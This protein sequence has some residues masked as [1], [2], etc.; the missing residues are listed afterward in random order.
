VEP[1]LIWTVMNLDVPGGVFSGAMGRFG[2]FG[3]M[4]VLTAL[5]LSATAVAQ[6]GVPAP[7][8]PDGS[9]AGSSGGPPAA[10]VKANGNPFTGG[11]SFT[12]KDVTV[13]VG[14]TV[15][16]TNTD[17]LVPHTATEDNGLWDLGGSYGPPGG[18]FGFGPGTSVERDFSAGTFNYFCKVH[19]TMRGTV[20]APVELRQKAKRRGFRQ[21]PGFRVIAVWSQIQLPAGQV[22]DVQKRKGAGAWKT[23]RDGTSKLRGRF[24]AREGSKLFF[25]AR[26]RK[27]AD[28]SAASDYSPPTKI[29]VG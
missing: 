10:Q 19:P 18:P 11:L 3:A 4:V 29:K 2:V 14:D 21:G 26:V 24:A 25:R 27:T 15:R 23:V 13:Q 12:P 6:Y 7:S 28:P 8:V 16:W 1:I 17:Y 22:F 5:M 9:G 20:S